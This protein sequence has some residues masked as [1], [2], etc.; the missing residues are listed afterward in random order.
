[1]TKLGSWRWYVGSDDDDDEMLDSG[2]LEQAL[3]DGARE[4]GPTFYLVEARMSVAHE[5]AMGVGER[6]TAP[7][8]ETRN[9]R[10]VGPQAT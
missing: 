2:T 8:A 5:D 6:D 7:F 3:I 1:M 9:G 10:W 4:Y